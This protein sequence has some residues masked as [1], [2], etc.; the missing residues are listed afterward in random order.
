MQCL[1]V[2]RMHSSPRTFDSLRSCLTS[3]SPR[4]R[5]RSSSPPPL[6]PKGVGSTSNLDCHKPVGIAERPRSFSKVVVFHSLFWPSISFC[7]LA[8]SRMP[9]TAS[10][11]PRRAASCSGVKPCPEMDGLAR[12]SSRTLITSGRW[13][14][15]ATCSEVL[16]N[17]FFPSLSFAFPYV[18]VRL[19]LEEFPH[20]RCISVEGRDMEGVDSLQDSD[21]VMLFFIY[22]PPVVSVGPHP[23]SIASKVLNCSA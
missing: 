10:A 6:P 12:F 3:S 20:K 7:C 14:Q 13:C 11:F 22:A 19:Q 5:Q 23:D 21:P 1:V 17:V 9:C 18:Y 8:V 16:F 15:I 2:S 4:I